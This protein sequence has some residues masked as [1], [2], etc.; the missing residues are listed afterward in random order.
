MVF[1]KMLSALGVGGP[2]VET[3][4]ANPNTR[5][6][7]NVEGQ[8][9]IVGGDHPVDISYIALGLVTRVEVESADHEYDSTVEFHRLPVTGGF[10]LPPGA[11]HTVPFS[12]PMPWETPITDMYGQRLHGMTMGLRTELEVARALDKGDLDAVSVHPL[13]AQETLLEAFSRLGF[14][15]KG[16]DLERGHVRGVAQTLPFY[17]EIELYAAPQYAH[18]LSEVEVTFVTNAHA[19][20]MILELDKRGGLFG[21]GGDMFLHITVPHASAQHT[22]W[23]S[24]IDAWLQQTVLHG[25]HHA[26]HHAGHHGGGYPPPPP[27]AYGHHTPPV[28]HGGHHGGHGYRHNH[29]GGHGYRHAQQGYGAGAV[30]GAAAAGAVTGFVAGE[31]LDEVFDEE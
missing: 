30:L 6:G 1:K 16:A 3:V 21:G 15:F 31:I 13:P 23:A 17:Q 19:V 7:L 4:L 11:R 25:G 5:P 14:R 24:Q 10:H 28:Y 9:H 22:D 8:I 20:E 27:P 18:A 29:H 26:G 2:Q 12:F